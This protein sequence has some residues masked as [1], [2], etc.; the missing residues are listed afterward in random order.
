MKYIYKRRIAHEELG[1]YSA[2]ASSLLL[3]KVWNMWLQN[4]IGARHKVRYKFNA[5][6]STN[7]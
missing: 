6:T 1:S 7:S 2:A 5:I 4:S 3:G